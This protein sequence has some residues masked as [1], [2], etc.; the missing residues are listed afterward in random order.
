MKPDNGNIRLSASD[1]SSHLACHH[2]TTNEIAVARSQ[3][4]AP[5]WAS[6]DTWV[7][8]QHG[9]EHER[10]YLNNLR[11]SGLIVVDLGDI[12]SEA[13]ASEETQTAMKNGAEVI[14]Q[15]TIQTGRWFG[16]AD[17]LRRVNKP[18]VLGS[19]SYEVYDC[20]LARETKAATI[21]QLCLYSELLAHLQG[22][23]PEVMHVVPRREGFSPE[24]YRVLDFVAYYRLVKSRLEQAID[25]RAPLTYPEPNP[26]CE[27][28]RWWRECDIRWRQDDHLSLVAG[29]TK[30][31]RKQLI[32]WGAPTLSQLAALP[33]PLRERPL[34]GAVD[35]YVTV[36]EQARVQLASRYQDKP[37]FEILEMEPG[38]G[39]TRLP[40]PSPGDI[41]FDFEG[42]PFV[43]YT[44]LE[45][46]LG[47]LM[48]DEDGEPLYQY[49]WS[50]DSVEEKLAFEWFIDLVTNA[51][52]RYPSLHIYHF[53]PYEPSTIKRLMGRYAS[54]E[55]EVDR[56]LRASIF[57]D[58]HSVV[59]QSI[60]A[61]VEQYS[62][63]ALEQVYGFF[64]D[65]RLGE[66]GFAKRS[67]EHCLELER[68]ADIQQADQRI[69][70]GYNRDDC[71]S[72]L[73]L[74]DWLEE[75][76]AALIA[77][78][79]QISRPVYEDGAAPL[80]V[81]E[82]QQRV[83]ALY[84]NL[85]SNVPVSPEPRSEEQ[86][87]RCLLANLL[88]WHRRE[89]K[90]EWWEFFRLRELSDEELLHEKAA[91]SGLRWERRIGVEGKLPIDRYR[92]DPQEVELRTN[93][94]L[95]YRGDRIGTV[96][97]IDLLTNSI[98]IK[99]AQKT[100]DAHPSS[101][102]GFSRVDSTALAES[103]F[104]L[105]LW[106][107]KNGLDSPG[108]YRAARDLLLRQSPRLTT[109]TLEPI[110][111]AEKDVV[112][113][114]RRIAMSLDCSVLAIQGPPGAGKTYTGARM[115]CELVRNGKKV[116]IT[117]LSHK[118]I[119]NLLDEMIRA[120]KQTD[121]A[122]LRCLEKVNEKSE[123]PPPGIHETTKNEEL[124][125]TLNLA[126]GQVVAGTAWVWSRQEFFEKLDV[127]FV[128]EAG[129]M[130]LANV[131]SVAQ[132]TK[133]LVLLGD[134]Q[135]LQQ[136]LKGSHLEGAEA[137]ALEHLLAGAKTIAPD[138]GLFLE[139]TWRLHPAICSFS[140]EL[141]YDDRLRSHTGLER[142]FVSGHKWMTESGLWFV[143][144][145]HE[146][147]QNSS[148][149]E[150]KCIAELIDSLLQPEV[151][152][153]NHEGKNRR[154]QLD[155]ILIVTPY[156]A[157]V[158]DIGTSIKGARAGTV[159]KFQGQEAPVVIYSLTTS[160][161]E[162]APRGMEFLYSLNR[163]NVATSRPRALCIVVGNP[164]LFEPECRSPR[165]MQLA[166]ALCRY[167]E[168][169]RPMRVVA[170]TE[171]EGFKILRTTA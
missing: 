101:V 79:Q 12:E 162:D 32:M 46:L 124:L 96:A 37:L 57:V 137:S 155:D 146:G 80:K 64:R 66:V 62:L 38:Y 7:L 51:L 49:R 106:V 68:A 151:M 142:Q 3:K 150:I 148:P 58:L 82:R 165:Q 156:N 94:T 2:V 163:L 139:E 88:D 130:S 108:A 152:W 74:R 120:G 138:R 167:L 134:P 39:L 18:S 170:A 114:A 9:L 13:R 10:N 87:A 71:L 53:T 125:D 141:F 69:V 73:S 14:A 75:Q 160:S 44:G 149:E 54:R 97:D 61:G 23:L 30:L 55:E 28:C 77:S 40:E 161:P 144:I 41:F 90:A 140:S 6:P 119:R 85:V 135:Q 65:V 19:W 121:V 31:Q 91:V 84:S 127:L 11:E 117:A 168:M 47:V 48:L 111:A 122:G 136:P 102:F 116:G 109:G 24:T 15:A 63:K 67:I 56:L 98:D 164:R 145:D 27:V 86:A 131:L 60:R 22:V 118:V 50:R 157:Q 8:R 132:A 154:L 43:G 36:R 1:L 17:V 166:N 4:A 35:G 21:L 89:D 171:I 133:N 70:E 34:H 153:L 126:G 29:I 100:A 159:D 81:D 25:G 103:L 110:V 45:Y 105:G 128:D 78:G 16:R 5:E 20:K 52:V 95:H 83:A 143:P 76:R 112:Q 42:D 93:E 104:R 147:N 123:A 158:S 33:L 129:Q 169:S 26:H 72:T 92:F 115:I 113:A 99:K 107:H 59:K